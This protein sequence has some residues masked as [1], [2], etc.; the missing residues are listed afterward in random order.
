M[1][2]GY[3]HSNYAHNRRE[4]PK[5]LRGS[6]KKSSYNIA[7]IKPVILESQ[8]VPQKLISPMHQNMVPLL[9]DNESIDKDLSVEK[10][11]GPSIGLYQN[12]Q[13]KTPW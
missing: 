10:L 9:E 8:V 7:T 4:E 3:T 12:I 2:Y 11:E 6:K 5:G 13:Y 1:G